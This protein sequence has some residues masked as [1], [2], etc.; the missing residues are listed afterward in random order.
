[1]LQKNISR[2]LGLQRKHTAANCFLNSPGRENDGELGLAV[3]KDEFLF[4]TE[5]GQL[6]GLPFQSI[7]SGKTFKTKGKQPFLTSWKGAM[8][9]LATE[10]SVDSLARLKAL[11]KLTLLNGRVISP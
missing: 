4:R 11:S 3:K 8:L 6:G 9:T 1:M 10:A 2:W 7:L 5:R